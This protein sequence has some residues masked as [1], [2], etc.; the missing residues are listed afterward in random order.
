[1]LG[2]GWHIP[3]PRNCQ[4]AASFWLQSCRWAHSLLP[5]ALQCRHPLGSQNCRMKNSS[6][7]LAQL[8]DRH[9][10]TLSAEHVSSSPDLHGAIH[11]HIWE[12]GRGGHWVLCLP[13]LHPTPGDPTLKR[14]A[15][16]TVL[17][18]TAIF[19]SISRGLAETCCEL[20]GI[21]HCRRVQT[22]GLA[23]DC[24]CLEG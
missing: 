4:G 22:T 16:R 19:I 6:F 10:H 1:M 8:L 23:A 24:L 18:C 13:A 20:S 2:V 9:V 3:A 15:S 14:A 11:M 12:Q 7:L 21:S 17:S 5:P